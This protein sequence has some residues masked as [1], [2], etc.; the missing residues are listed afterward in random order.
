M[1]YDIQVFVTLKEGVLDPQGNAVQTSLTRLGYDGVQNVRIGKKMDIRME[2][3]PEKVESDVR[4]MC[5]K[6]LAN[7][8][9]EDYEYTIEEALSV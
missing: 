7:P 1:T 5:E 2:S 9:I 6:L 4:E 3:E 8:V